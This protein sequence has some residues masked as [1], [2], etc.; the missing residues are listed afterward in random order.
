M[1]IFFLRSSSNYQK[2]PLHWSQSVL[3]F[4][5]CNTNSLLNNTCI[6]DI[7]VYKYAHTFTH[8]HTNSADSDFSRSSLNLVQLT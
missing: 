1:F 2:T 4:I 8:R 3:L 5:A 6:T 7:Y